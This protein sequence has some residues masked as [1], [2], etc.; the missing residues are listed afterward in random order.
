MQKS[1]RIL[2][3]LLSSIKLLRVPRTLAMR[4]EAALVIIHLE[5][6]CCILGHNLDN[7]HAFISEAHIQACS[8]AC[9]LL[10][11]L[12]AKAENLNFERGAICT[13]DC[14]RRRIA[15]DVECN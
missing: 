1:P 11:K 6:L 14:E 4:G 5:C 15:N 13:A 12:A 8:F 2:H 9:E 3:G 10:F 7:L